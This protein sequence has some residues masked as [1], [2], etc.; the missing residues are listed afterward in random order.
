MAPRGG[1]IN[2]ELLGPLDPLSREMLPPMRR[3]QVSHSVSRLDKRAP[4]IPNTT[5]AALTRY[6]DVEEQP[7]PGVGDA[8]AGCGRRWTGRHARGSDSW[9]T[10]GPIQGPFGR[11]RWARFP[12][13]SSSFHSCVFSPSAR[14]MESAPVLAVHARPENHRAVAF[15]SAPV[16]PKRT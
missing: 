13:L 12:N 15:G 9:S 3:A 6:A 5:C 1:G 11:L 4:T 8:V 2:R 16:A 10:G 14:E 7:A